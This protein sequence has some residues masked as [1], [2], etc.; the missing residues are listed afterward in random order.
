MKKCITTVV[1]GAASIAAHAQSNVSIYGLIDEGITVE[2]NGLGTVKKLES[3][4]TLGSRL[5]FI[6]SEDLGGGLSAVFNLEMGLNADDGS[7]GAGFNRMS[8]V[9][10]KSATAGTVQFGR[11]YVPIYLSQLNIDP[12][13][14]GYK[15]DMTSG[16]GFFESFNF[17]A[18]NSVVYLS[19]NISGWN[20]SAM[21][22]FGEAS[23]NISANRQLGASADYSNGPIRASVAYHRA[24]TADGTDKQRSFFLGATYDFG[25][26]KIHVAFDDVKGLGASK[27]RDTMVGISAPVGA[28]RIT[29]SV[30]NKDNRAI[31]NANARQY[32]IGYIH[33]L[34]KR[35]SLYTSFAYVK[36]DQ[37]SLLNSGGVAGASD[38]VVSAGI[39]H[40]F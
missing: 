17:W 36:N 37:K 38:R 24:N 35:T 4:V 26:V 23:N 3:G 39:R 20:I 40:N 11:Q 22:G 8:I 1:I 28:G 6:G 16:R 33:S 21:Y 18:N 13:T 15:G 25:V 12:F 14:G 32:G 29:A 30:V 5:G 34:S 27:V 9:G 2:R 19:P 10:L 31:A 7:A